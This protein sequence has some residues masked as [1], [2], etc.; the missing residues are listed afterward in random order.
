MFLIQLKFGI[1]ISQLTIFG[2]KFRAIPINRRGSG[3]QIKY[4]KQC[5]VHPPTFDDT[6]I[7]QGKVKGLKFARTFEQLNV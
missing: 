7:S 2:E 5:N 6:S 1:N 3:R 4:K